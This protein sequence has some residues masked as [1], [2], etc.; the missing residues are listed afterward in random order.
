MQSSIQLGAYKEIDFPIVMSVLHVKYI[1]SK[2]CFK[3][4]MTKVY[5]KIL[6]MKSSRNSFIF[7]P[8][9]VSHETS[10]EFWKNNHFEN[11]RADFLRR[12]Q[13]SLR[14]TSPEMMHFQA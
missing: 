13:A 7:L 1:S 8:D 10:K 9:C 12:C 5:S 2:L 3:T 11:M 14:Q 4:K 6:L